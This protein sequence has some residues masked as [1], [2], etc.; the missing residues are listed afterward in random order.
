MSLTFDLNDT[1][2][3]AFIGYSIS[4]VIFGIFTTQ[5]ISFYHRYRTDPLN[6]KILVGVVWCTELLH[7]TLVAHALYHYTVSLFGSPIAVFTEPVEW[8]LVTQV[9]VGAISGSIVKA[10]RLEINRNKI[11][12]TAL[13]VVILVQIGCILGSLMYLSRQHVTNDVYIT[14]YEVG[15][16]HLQNILDIAKIKV[17][18][19]LAL[20]TGALAD[21]LIAVALCYYLRKLRTGYREPDSLLNSLVQYA[22][23]TG[24]LTSTM[25]ILTLV[26]YDARTSTFQYMGVYFVLSKMFAVSFMCALSTR[27]QVTGK[28]GDEY[29]YTNGGFGGFTAESSLRTVNHIDPYPLKP[30]ATVQDSSV[31]M[32]LGS[33]NA[34]NQ[35]YGVQNEYSKPQISPL[36]RKVEEV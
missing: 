34:E 17:V 5:A 14:A 22:L 13:A 8:S 2:G 1:L 15:A 33:W 18:A 25:S 36:R 16:F 3:A 31:S 23:N 27:K 35:L 9:L 19:S 24:A 29:A 32:E 10:S 30:Q 21:F 4:C 12:T 20:A 7:Q 6:L 28:I 11:V 26:L